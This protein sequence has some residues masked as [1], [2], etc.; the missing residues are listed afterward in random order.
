MRHSFVPI[1]PGLALAAAAVLS[2]V[3]LIPAFTPAPATAQPVARAASHGQQL[4]AVIRRTTDGTPHILARNWADLGFG[5][6]FAF[7]QDNI[8]TMANDYVTVEAQRS[9]Y[10][11][12]TGSYDSRGSGASAN[13]LNSDLFYQQIINSHVIAGLTKGLSPQLSQIQA[14][15]VSGYNKYLASVGGSKGVPDPTCRGKA[16]VKPITER[17]SF[18][19]FYQL[20][21]MSSSSS[22]IDSIVGAQPPAAKAKAGAAPAAL[23]L[24]NPRA[25]ARKMIATYRAEHAEMGSN[26]VAIGS[27]GTRNHHGLLLGNPHFPWIGSERFYQAQL[28]I[29]GKINVTGASLYGVPAVL[30][31]HNAN[32]AWSHT[33]STA[34]RFTPYQLKIVKGHPTEYLQN[35]HPVKMTAHKVTVMALQGNGKLAPVTRTLYS[36]RYGPMIN[37]LLGIPLPWTKSSAFTMRDANATNLARALDTWFGIDRATSTQQVLTTIKKFQGIPWVNTIA[38]DKQGTALYADIGSIPGVPNSLAKKCDTGLGTFTFAE[39]GLPI[40]DGSK[41]SCNWITGPHAAA[42]GLMGP[43]QEPFLLR[44]DFVTNSN[45]SYWLANPHHPLT[46][47]ARI[48]GDEQTPRTLRTRIGLIE[49][50]ARIDGTDGLG[51]RGFTLSALQNLD[52]SDVDYAGELTRNALVTMCRN[53]SKTNNGFAPTSGGGK[54]KIG[55]ACTVL[56][57]WSLHW[58]PADRGAVLFGVF[59]GQ[60]NGIQPSPFTHPFLASDPVNT[61]FGLNTSNKKVKQALGDSITALNNAHIPLNASLASIQFVTYQGKHIP[62]PGGPGDPDGIYNAIYRGD[63]SGDSPTAPDAGSSFIQAVTWNSTSCPVG[64]TILTYSESSNPDSPHFADQTKL[65]SQKKWLTDRFCEAQIS[66]DPNLTITT[67]TGALAK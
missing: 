64:A 6:G 61:P 17:D 45:D 23:A 7:A 4:R 51:P 54:V 37:D 42:P 20:M 33:V 62:I 57:H 9:K 16:W 1:R 18:L 30:I 36:T 65:F 60:A 28:T 27:Q 47:F 66:A 32:V 13:N 50:Q 31:G 25:A 19:R 49:V 24:T 39:A 22:L 43:N 41:T 8:C 26:A 11:G 59:W 15:Y 35:G 21:L 55:N 14:G 10:F 63:V 40:L 12:P 52:L 48:I 58:N 53:L 38:S 34:F 2:G 46:G 29:P 44:K 67:V 56:A 5:Y 3:S